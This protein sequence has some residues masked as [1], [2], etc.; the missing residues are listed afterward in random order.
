VL[1]S[2]TDALDD[3]VDSVVVTHSTDTM[4][5]VAFLAAPALVRSITNL[6]S[7]TRPQ[8]RITSNA[9]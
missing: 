1:R 7:K 2:I 3:D 6:R 8:P 9:T 5:E 4:E